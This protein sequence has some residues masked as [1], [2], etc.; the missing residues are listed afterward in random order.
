[1]T[2]PMK[3]NNFQSLDGWNFSTEEVSAGVYRVKG[4]DTKGRSFEKTGTDPEEILKSCHQ[5]AIS[6]DSQ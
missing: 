3:E 4:Y 6:M 2:T 1:M 5:D